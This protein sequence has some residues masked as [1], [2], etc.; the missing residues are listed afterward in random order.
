MKNKLKVGFDFDG[1]IAYNPLRIA[2]FPIVYFKRKIFGVHEMKFYYPKYA[3][4]QI[5]WRVLHKSSIFPSRGIKLL[6]QLVKNGDIE[7]HL[8]TGRYRFLDG[9]LHKWLHKHDL[10][11]I[12]TTINI[13]EENEQPHLFKEKI[14][15][16][17]NLQIFI[18][19]NWDIV[20]YLSQKNVSQIYW[21]YNIIDRK[22]EYKNKFP[23]LEKAIQEFCLNSQ[24]N[25]DSE[26]IGK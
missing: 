3:W 19:D 13:N 1:V 14:I 4:Q 6:K 20:N 16:K 8:I 9:D 21:I 2:R 24:K 17:H 5:F 10:R 23:Y 26:K 7:A 25:T 22:I 12:F 15:Q 11:D 18:E